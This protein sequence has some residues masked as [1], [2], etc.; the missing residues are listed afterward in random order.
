MSQDRAFCELVMMGTIYQAPIEATLKD[1]LISDAFGVHPLIWHG[2]PKALNVVD[3]SSEL[4]KIRQ[5]VLVMH[6]QFDALLPKEL[7]EE[8]AKLLPNGKFFEIPGRG[9]SSNVEDPALFVNLTDN[10]LFG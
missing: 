6:G 8:L 4:A 7:S 1:Q 5:P 10:F 3:I 2:V 9:H